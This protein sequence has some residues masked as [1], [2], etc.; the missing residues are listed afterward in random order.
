MEN[1]ENELYYNGKRKV[2]LKPYEVDLLEQIMIHR[3]MAAKG[4]HK[5]I[6]S[7]AKRNMNPNS[8]SNRLHVLLE[9]GLIFRKTKNI[10]V[11]R[12]LV[13]EY[14]YRLSVSGYA[15]LVTQHRI[16]EQEAKRY[17]LQVKELELPS[18]HSAAMSTLANN[19]VVEYRSSY[20]SSLVHSRS[21]PQEMIPSSL[22]NAIPDWVF[23][24]GNHLIFIE[25]D[26]GSQSQKI[27]SSKV[28]R[29]ELLK[30]YF[31]TKEIQLIVFFAVLD[32]T[33]SGVKEPRLNNRKKRVRSIKRTIIKTVDQGWQDYYVT[34]T[35]RAQKVVASLIYESAAGNE[36]KDSGLECGLLLDQVL[37]VKKNYEHK[38]YKWTTES[39]IDFTLSKIAG[40]RSLQYILYLSCKEGQVWTYALLEGLLTEKFQE[41]AT[42][43]IIE[44]SM[45]KFIYTAVYENTEYS[46]EDIHPLETHFQTFIT[47]IRT[48]K[49]AVARQQ[50]IPKMRELRKKPH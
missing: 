9:S 36:K 12:A 26:T 18:T 11:T 1:Y 43:S 14:Y 5:Y 19:I 20:E 33:V 6:Q 17:Y 8:I 41:F 44:N 25:L 23:R 3:W 42:K 34:S 45:N 13:P 27:V 7:H 38:L 2:V 28:K 37:F 50:K 46:K 16:T 10:S 47:D 4:I 32:S 48:W 22:R 39:T 29:Y 35:Q 30:E 40:S 31:K 24:F 49:R 21:V 15:L